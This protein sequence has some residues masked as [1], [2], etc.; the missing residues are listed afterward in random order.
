MFLNFHFYQKTSIFGT[1]KKAKTK[2]QKAYCFSRNKYLGLPTQA[3]HNSGRSLDLFLF[4]LVVLAVQN[5]RNLVTCNVEKLG[6]FMFSFVTI[7][8]KR[9]KEKTKILHAFL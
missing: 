7:E 6:L 4:S 3:D 1:E 5:L 9:K 8:H 2:K